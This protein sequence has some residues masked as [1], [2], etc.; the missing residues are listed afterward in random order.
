[1]T[2]LEVLLEEK[3]A[4]A[5]LSL[6]DLENPIASWKARR[7]TSCAKARVQREENG[8]PKGILTLFATFTTIEGV[9]DQG[10]LEIVEDAARGVD[11]SVRAVWAS[12]TLQSEL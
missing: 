4:C 9:R 12:N 2:V 5:Y 7:R 8:A 11:S 10:I 6:P 1:M 3:V